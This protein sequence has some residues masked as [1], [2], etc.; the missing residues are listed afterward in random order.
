MTSWLK[1]H[2]SDTVDREANTLRIPLPKDA[3]LAFFGHICSADDT[4][5]KHTLGCTVHWGYINAL[6]D[7][8]RNHLIEL[9][10][11][12]FLLKV[13][14]KIALGE[15]G[16]VIKSISSEEMCELSCT[17]EDS[18]SL[19]KRSS[20]YALGQINGPTPVELKAQ[21]IHFGKGKASSVAVR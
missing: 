8:Y 10:P 20:S 15:P 5:I 4:S 11:Q 14:T 18:H 6:V 21:H 12:R 16:R 3:I 13:T 2:H 19:R 1:D 7:A 17:S 9:D